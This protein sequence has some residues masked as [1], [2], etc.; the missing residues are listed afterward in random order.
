M[1][2]MLGIYVFLRITGP[3]LSQMYGRYVCVALPVRIVFVVSP[4]MDLF[5]E[6]DIGIC[7]QTKLIS[8]RDPHVYTTPPLLTLRY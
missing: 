1:Q 5:I 8:N 2:V 7:D 4:R 6:S 3:V